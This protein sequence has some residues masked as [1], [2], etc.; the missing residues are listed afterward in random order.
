MQSILSYPTGGQTLAGRGYHTV[1]PPWRQSQHRGLVRRRRHRHAARTPH[2]D[3]SGSQRGGNQNF[4]LGRYHDI[5]CNEAV[6]TRV[7][8]VGNNT[9]VGGAGDDIVVGDRA[10]EV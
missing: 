1:Y 8:T 5:A 7:G 6:A 10:T 3:P 2:T 9:L 4:P